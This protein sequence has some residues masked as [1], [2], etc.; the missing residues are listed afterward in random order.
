MMREIEV[1]GMD[2]MSESRLL[3]GVRGRAFS[4]SS[5]GARMPLLEAWAEDQAT[6]KGWDVQ[7]PMEGMVRKMC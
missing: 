7:R 2:R 3:V 6:E 4:G 5:S 1:C